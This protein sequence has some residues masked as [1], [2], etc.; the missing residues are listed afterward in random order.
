MDRVFVY[1]G[2]IP[3]SS[4]ILQLQRWIMEAHG[5]LIAGAIGR[6]TAFTGLQ[7][8]PTSPASMSVVV[9]PGAIFS[10][11]EIDTTAFGSLPANTNPLMKSGLSTSPTTFTLT[12]PSTS[13]YSV[14]YLIQVQ[15]Q[16]S[17]GN[18]TVLPY[19][20]AANP[21]QPFSGPGNNGQS[22]NTARLEIAALQLVTGVAAPTG[23]QVTPAVESGW[24]GL[25]V[26]TVNN[27]QISITAAD[28]S[29]YPG[30]PMSGAPFASLAGNPNQ[31][32]ATA[33]T[34]ANNQAPPLSQ[35]QAQFA[36]INGNGSNTFA[37]APASASAP[38]N[39]PQF[40]QM[41]DLQSPSAS[42]SITLSALR[43]IVIPTATAAITLTMEPGTT[44]GQWCEI[45]G[46]S[47]GVTV[48]SNVS[49]G[50]PLF[51]LPDGTDV[52]S[53]VLSTYGASLV[54]I[55]DGVNWR[56]QTIGQTVVAEATATNQAPP[57]WQ[58]QADFAALN[59][60]ANETFAV[61]AT[62]ASNQAP[63]LSQ[64]QAQFA[65]IGNVV[66]SFNGRQGAVSLTSG[67]VT[68][69]LTYIP[70]NLSGNPNQNFAA[71]AFLAYGLFYSPNNSGIVC[72]PGYTASVNYA[73]NAYV[74]HV[75]SPAA[76]TG[77]AVT[78]GQFTSSRNSGGPVIIERPDG[79][80]F[81][82]GTGTVTASGTGNFSNTINLPE[83]FPNAGLFAIG[84]WG[85]TNPPGG[86]SAFPFTTP[87]TTQVTLGIYAPGAGTFT[88]A[89]LAV[90]Y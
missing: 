17:D 77:E 35:I 27:G 14:N 89:Y 66:N 83:A 11:E 31:Q 50:S 71:N 9:N 43:T 59:G 12:A 41:F 75:C 60:N 58:I 45:V 10:L 49:S 24:Y 34:T 64:I 85:G 48:Q 65:A 3:R 26:I 67:D 61:A 76:N 40:G 81:Q 63:P 4:D 74:P 86:G 88:I 47:Y 13:G 38:Q 55:W 23:S 5:W 90:G 29:L 78:L 30:A 69:A 32:F 73:G 22:Q 54:L 20:N 36:P 79:L 2:E 33:P 51:T 28:I 68:S 6:N 19:Y 87:S 21:A 44:V 1:P 16:E 53:F 82:F 72:D 42:G 56:V 84:N 25:W 80:I 62:N 39:A 7:C 70:A 46:T 52:Y 15:F 37:V 8:V 57:L 18:P